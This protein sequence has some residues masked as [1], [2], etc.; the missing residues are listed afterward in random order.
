MVL[1]YTETTYRLE[2]R[3][4][5]KISIVF[6]LMCVRTRFDEIFVIIVSGKRLVLGVVINRSGLG[7]RENNRH[8]FHRFKVI[9]HF[10]C[11]LL[12]L[13]LANIVSN[14]EA[15]VCF[16]MS[17]PSVILHERKHSQSKTSVI[18][19]NRTINAILAAS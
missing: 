2:T 8:L 3:K 11:T 19:T 9:R 15:T 12:F 6:L 4:Y 5:T 18:I 10:L 17:A 14:N 7:V 13:K 1:L 16:F